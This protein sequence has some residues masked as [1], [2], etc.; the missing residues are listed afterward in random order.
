MWRSRRL[1]LATPR[2]IGDANIFKPIVALILPKDHF[3]S[4]LVAGLKFLDNRWI[5][6]AVR[7]GHGGHESWNVAVFD[8]NFAGRRILFDY[9]ALQRIL[10][11]AV[12]ANRY[13]Q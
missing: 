6:D 2:F 5:F 1:R 7:H 8:R 12:A 13:D 4:D 3:G 11:G 9:F 10:S